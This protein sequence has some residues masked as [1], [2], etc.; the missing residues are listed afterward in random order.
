M[1]TSKSKKILFITIGNKDHASSRIRVLQY[2]P[3]VESCNYSI[4]W[5]PRIPKHKK[6]SVFN[7]ILFAIQKRYYFIIRCLNLIR[8]KW[9][10]IFI[11]KDFIPDWILNKIKKN[12]IPIIFDFDDA[13]YLNEKSE[14]K[15]LQKTE[16]LIRV[17]TAI[18]VSSEILEKF[19]K[20]L[21]KNPILI[22]S[23]VDTDKLF[24]APNNKSNKVCIGWI[25][26]PWTT[27]YL[28]QLTQVFKELSLKY[29]FELVIVGAKKDFIIEGINITNLNWSA[30]KENE[31]LNL[32]DIGI[33]PLTVDKYAEG[34]GGYKLLQ[35]MSIGI[36]SVASPVGINN[37]IIDPG[38][39]GY[40]AS[41]PED[42]IHYLEQLI[43]N[44]HLRTE[45]GI[46]AREK[47]L[48]EYS[49]IVN[50][51]KF[52]SVLELLSNES[53]K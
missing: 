2:F 41:K 5:M 10:I 11:Q 42:W 40:L 1:V 18:I 13:I 26:S 35:Y 34:K 22:N 3:F 17:A 38:K 7:S 50:S 36:P 32:M 19:C 23:P 45:M 28:Y 52:L 49:L 51:K 15:N 8:K 31:Y 12:N 48:K 14:Q 33:M 30:E 53:E 16:S 29:D 21:G 25:G 9:D 24:P 37:Q 47:V 6:H 39:N 4:K 27:K 44:K 46:A 20:Q 43:S